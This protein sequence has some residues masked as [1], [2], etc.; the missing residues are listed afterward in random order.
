MARIRVMRRGTTAQHASFVGE[1]AEVTVDT[2]KQVAV[3]H[4]NSSAGGFPL[5]REI[6]VLTSGTPVATQ[7][8][9][10]NFT[11]GVG[12][13]ESTGTIQVGLVATGVTAGTYSFATVTVDAAGRITA[14]SSGGSFSSTVDFS[15]D[16][17][18]SGSTGSTIAMTLANSGVTPGTYSIATVTVDAKG[19]V[20]QIATGAGGGGNVTFSGDATG[21]GAVGSTIALTLANSGASAG[22]YTNTRVVVDSK[23]RVTSATSG[24]L[25]WECGVSIHGTMTGAEVVIRMPMA[26]TIILPS[27]L[28]ESRAVANTAATVDSNFTLRKNGTLFGTIAFLAGITTGAYSAATVTTFAPGD[29][30]TVTSPVTPDAT[31]ADVGLTIAGS[32]G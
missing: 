17:T 10:V 14:A 2:D 9:N 7:P 32:R 4:D 5:Q 24:T 20:T 8:R 1:L 21:T 22:T 28:T 29:I 19:R 27:G 11:N 16:V 31:L 13:S 6:A 18:G 23:G 30:F 26:R 15:G 3:V 25:P 12:A